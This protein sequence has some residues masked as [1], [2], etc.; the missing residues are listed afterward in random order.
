[1]YGDYTPTDMEIADAAANLILKAAWVDGCL[2]CH[3]EP[4]AK[5]YSYIS[6]GGRN[7][8]KIRAH[9]LIWIARFGPI[10]DDLFVLHKCDN[11]RCIYDEHLFLGTALDNTKDM[12]NKERAKFVQPR[13]D[14]IRKDKIIALHR[15]GFKR[16]EIARRLLISES[17]V[18][19]YISPRGPYYVGD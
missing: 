14:H 7:G 2:E 9:R 8:I 1:M 19:N 6:I 16:S 10:E 11:R 12:V 17:T 5:G 15:Q 13:T 4:N 18:W 3:L